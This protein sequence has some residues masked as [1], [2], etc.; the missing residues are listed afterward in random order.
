MKRFT[1][2]LGLLAGALLLLPTSSQAVTVSL[3]DVTHSGA[4]SANFLHI[5][6]TLTFTGTY[7]NSDDVYGFS[8][9]VDGYDSDDNGIADN[10]LALVSGDVGLTAFA[11]V[12]AG[13]V[14]YGGL[15]NT[16]A[17][18]TEV[19]YFNP[20]CSLSGCPVIDPL[21]VRLFQAVSTT[22]GTGDGQTDLGISSNLVSS[23][24]VHFSV[25]FEA[26]AG[27]GAYETRTLTFGEIISQGEVALGS[28]GTLLPYTSD[29]YS[30]TVVP[31]PGTAMLM[32]LGLASLAGVS[33]RR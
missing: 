26:V 3:T 33:R 7:S 15:N 23:G 21:R 30:F 24:D 20:F 13:G 25:T 4:G 28:G 2:N 5:G 27:L 12:V 19:G 6:D 14:A 22:P 9:A 17:T 16:I 32:G 1:R 31:E 18:A 11:T 10:G 8:V 29:S